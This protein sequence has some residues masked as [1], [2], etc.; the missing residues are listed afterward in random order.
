MAECTYKLEDFK[1]CMSSKSMHPQ[2][3]YDAWIR[4]KAEWWA[5]RRM[6]KSSEDVWEVRT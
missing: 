5:R 2:E 1:H 6:S 4:R 3:K